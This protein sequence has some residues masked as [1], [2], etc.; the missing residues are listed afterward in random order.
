MQEKFR[1]SKNLFNSRAI[2]AVMVLLCLSVVPAQ[3]AGAADQQ[4]TMIPAGSSSLGTTA[5]A[6]IL[7][8]HAHPAAMLMKWWQWV[9]AAALSILTT[10]L[11]VAFPQCSEV[12]IPTLHAALTSVFEPGW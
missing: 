1:I 7:N 5:H 2:M 4:M 3:A 8:I 11:V 12:A 6:T 9:V 10:A